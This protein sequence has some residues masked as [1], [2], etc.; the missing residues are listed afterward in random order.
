[1]GY[2]GIPVAALFADVPGFKVTGLQRRS[3][4][5][6]WKIDALNNGESPIG[7]DEP[8]LAE[9]VKKVVEQGS[10]KATDDV[11]AYREADAI[12]IAVQT[13]VDE[14]HQPQYE[15][16][17][18][19]LHDI[20][21]NLNPGTLVCLES[22]IA[23]GTTNYIAKPILEKESGLKAGEDFNLV[24]S[25]ERVMVGRLL[26]N[27]TMYDRIVGGV[28]PDCTKKGIELYS[29][30]VKAKLHPTDAL[31]A[32]VAKVTE[33]AYRD[34]NIAFANEIAIICESLG[35]NVHN[36]R[37]FVNN[38]PNDPSTP[39]ANPYRNMHTPGAGVGGHCLPK[40]SWLLKYG[41]DTYGK[42]KYQPTIITESRK[43]NDYMPQHMKTLLQDALKEHQL[44]IKQV[45]ATILGF[46]F[47]ENSDDPRNTPAHPLYVLLKDECRQVVIH[48]PHIKQ[49]EDLPLTDN[50]QKALTDSDCILIVTRH[51]EYTRLTLDKLKHYMKT[52]L[53]IDGRNVIDRKE[54]KTKGFTY[55][56]VGQPRN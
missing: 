22:T 38:L 8:G 45:K 13:P 12:L 42:L 23:P 24:F 48:D 26:H 27:L 39:N 31:T 17:K 4:R 53:I 47:L 20:G 50:L 29:H 56:G 7:G 25:Y 35:V 46:A 41:H 55:R 32:E 21:S 11:S 33:N 5:S 6:S 3:P 14:S 40:D 49:Y 30:I 37:R 28:T 36:I 44:D 10:F 2:V 18:Q 15:S 9:L 51:K 16:L 54:A 43:L 52:P 1:M 19:V 34:V